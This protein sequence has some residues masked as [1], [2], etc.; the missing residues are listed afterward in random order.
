M[1]TIS[2]V[3]QIALPFSASEVFAWHMRPCALER[4]IPPWDR[5][6]IL[7]ITGSVSTPNSQVYLRIRFGPFS[8]QFIVEHTDFKRGES[9]TDRQVKGPFRSWVHTHRVIPRSDQTCEWEDQLKITLPFWMPKFL[10]RKKLERMLDWRHRRLVNELTIGKRYSQGPLKILISGSHGLVGKEMVAFLRSQGHEVWKLHRKLST[11]EHNVI[12]WDPN[13]ARFSL[14]D[15]ENFDAVIHLAGKNI[16][17]KFWTKKIKHELFTSRARDTWLLSQLLSRLKKPPKVV[18]SASAVGFYG[19]RGEEV[20]TEAS[21]KGE[22]FLSEVCQKWEEALDATQHKGVRVVQSRF[23]II[24]SQKGGML[25]KLIPIF[26]LG[27]GAILGR[28]EQKISWITLDDVI[29]GL[30][31][32]LHT[33]T[34]AGPVNFTAPTA[35]TNR[36]FSKILAKSLNRP[37]FLRIPAPILRLLFGQMAQEMFLSSTHAYP[38][39][40]LDSHF[41]FLYP[42]I[43]QF[44]NDIY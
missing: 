16:A 37:L 29:Y 38:E 3:K 41:V 4:M 1:G 31:H 19:D 28:G 32:T 22:G 11:R 18:I 24:L 7:H 15:F 8:H 36:S 33:S 12:A 30:Y 27:L 40:L 34:L 10:I 26:R 13:N 20:L 21:R 25:R 42:E 9:F 23:G 2:I 14:L 5:T 6:E 17:S 39:K 35:E 44:L 43:T